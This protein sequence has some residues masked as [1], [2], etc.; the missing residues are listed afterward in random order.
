M[1]RFFILF[2]LVFL[3]NIGISQKKLQIGAHL[4]PA[5]KLNLH[6]SKLTGIRSNESGFGFTAGI[7]VKYWFNDYTSFNTGINYDF[8]SF[9]QFINQ[10]L[11]SSFRI[12]ALELPLM[13]SSNVKGNWYAM[14]GLGINYNLWTRVLNLAG[15]ADVS[16]LTHKV[17]P[18]LGIGLNRLIEQSKGVF[19]VGILGRLQL[20]DIWNKTY[21]PS[22]SVTSK[23]LSLDLLLRYYI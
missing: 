12:S 1:Q 22:K 17:Q 11:V 20:R 21:A 13:L 16:E 19:E 15:G 18:Y 4:A 5:W 3:G 10:Q 8:T 7:P 14:Y 2:L 23:L 9:D 6:R